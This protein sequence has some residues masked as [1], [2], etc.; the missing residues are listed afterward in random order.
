MTMPTV[1]PAVADAELAKIRAAEEAVAEVERTRQEWRVQS[2]EALGVTG[3]SGDMPP[4]RATLRKYG[5]SAYPLAALGVLSI[6][7]TFHGYAFAVLAPEVSSA[8]GV[9]RSAIAL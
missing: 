5:V 8:L 9:S 2:R 3:A 7:D 4:L 1:D 6:V